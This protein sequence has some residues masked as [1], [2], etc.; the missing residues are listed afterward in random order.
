MKIRPLLNVN[1]TNTRAIRFYQKF[2]F[3]II[4]AEIIPQCNEAV[5]LAQYKMKFKL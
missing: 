4:G 2:G 3:E 1:Q 5:N